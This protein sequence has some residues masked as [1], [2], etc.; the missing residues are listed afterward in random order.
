MV[1]FDTTSN[2][3]P[4]PWTSIRFNCIITIRL[5][6][7]KFSRYSI[8][9]ASG[10][11]NML[12]LFVHWFVY[13]FCWKFFHIRLTN[14]KPG[15]SRLNSLILP[16]P[17]FFYGIMAR[18]GRQILLFIYIYICLFILYFFIVSPDT[19][20]LIFNNAML[21]NMIAQMLDLPNCP[22]NLIINR[23]K[24]QFNTKVGFF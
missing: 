4:R 7:I 6:T 8:F 10:I 18:P 21:E 20:L 23:P 16:E 11:N 3:T 2:L 14:L 9:A 22:K 17:P 12:R 15:S 24:F 19:S 5:I 13:L 1:F